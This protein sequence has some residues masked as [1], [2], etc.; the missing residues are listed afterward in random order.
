M[1]YWLH[2]GLDN[3]KLEPIT[4]D[5][6]NTRMTKAQRKKSLSCPNSP[7]P[8]KKNQQSLKYRNRKLKRWKAQRVNSES[9][10]GGRRHHQPSLRRNT[11]AAA[12]LAL[13]S[14][15]AAADASIT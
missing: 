12:V 3:C 10:A 8:K 2:T 6:E 4:S 1:S 5:L 9:E 7:S 14:I 13:W 11:K 15:S